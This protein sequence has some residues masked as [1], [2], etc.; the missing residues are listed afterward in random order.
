MK[1]FFKSTKF[2]VFVSVLIFFGFGFYLLRPG[3]ENK[4]SQ[5]SDSGVYYSPTPAVESPA[6][7]KSKFITFLPIDNENYLVE[8]FPDRDYFFVQIRKNPYSFYKKQV[9]DIFGQFKIPLNSVNVEWSSVRGV[10]P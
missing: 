7:N 6:E 1:S 10:G 5:G 3:D 9:E 8:Y 2:K 4:E